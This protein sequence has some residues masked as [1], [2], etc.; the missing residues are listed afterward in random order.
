MHF[1]IVQDANFSM[2]LQS[3]CLRASPLGM[4]A[5]KNTVLLM[6]NLLPSPLLEWFHYPFLPYV[7]PSPQ[8]CPR[9]ALGKQ[10]TQGRTPLYFALWLPPFP[11]H[12]C[13]AYSLPLAVHQSLLVRQCFTSLSWKPST[14]MNYCRFCA[15]FWLPLSC[16]YLEEGGLDL[17]FQRL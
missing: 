8:V 5:V 3:K 16:K 1:I 7:L 9:S 14:G 13:W 4:L 12:L 11:I 17:I 10:C 15:C 2:I 6:K